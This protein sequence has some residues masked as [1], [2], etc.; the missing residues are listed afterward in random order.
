MRIT[1]TLLA[2]LFQSVS[3]TE[4]ALERIFGGGAPA[5]KSDSASSAGVV[6][7]T[8]RGII[9]QIFSFTCFFFL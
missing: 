1:K 9:G 8:G 5:G 6:I 7:G 2:K 4:E 3:R